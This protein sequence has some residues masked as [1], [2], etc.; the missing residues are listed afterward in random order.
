MFNLQVKFEFIGFINTFFDIKNSHLGEL[1]L[2]WVR[3][4]V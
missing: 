3:E 1:W 2:S 4:V